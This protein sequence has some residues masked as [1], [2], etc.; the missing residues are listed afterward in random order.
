MVAAA[1]LLFISQFFDYSKRDFRAP[2]VWNDLSLHGGHLNKAETG[3]DM[4]SWYSGIAIGII[5][6]LFYSNKRSLP[7]YIV[8][9]IIML[10]LALGEGKGAIMGAVSIVLA[11]YAI[12]LKNKEN[13]TADP[14]PV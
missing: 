12:Y 2:D 14:K 6:C 4:H 9:T 5:A 3:W 1:C 7:Y 8:S 10:P 13:K 11:G